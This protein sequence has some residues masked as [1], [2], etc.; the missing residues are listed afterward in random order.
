MRFQGTA[1]AVLG[2]LEVLGRRLMKT[3]HLPVR[4]SSWRG[5][6]LSKLQTV[7][8]PGVL[9]ADPWDGREA[10]DDG[11]QCGEAKA[12]PTTQGISKFLE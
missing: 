9:C 2:D 4:P 3:R 6:P 10:M 7:G 5:V 1:L 8:F 12:V 11:Q